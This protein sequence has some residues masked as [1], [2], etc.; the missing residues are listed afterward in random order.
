MEFVKGEVSYRGSCG[1]DMLAARLSAN[2]PL[3]TGALG[4]RALRGSEHQAC[5][6]LI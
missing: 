3:L 1:R 6:R 5:V 4:D 2:D